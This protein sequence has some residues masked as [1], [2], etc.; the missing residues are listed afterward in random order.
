MIKEKGISSDN[1]NDDKF[2]EAYLGASQRF[3][4]ILKHLEEWLTETHY[5]K[6]GENEARNY[7]EKRFSEV[8]KHWESI[9]TDELEAYVRGR[10][11]GSY[12]QNARAGR[13][14]EAKLNLIK[15]H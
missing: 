12:G 5:A 4:P 7:F 1:V 2:V 15:Q 13:T 14:C 3:T 10:Q 9:S 11:D 8:F 6:G